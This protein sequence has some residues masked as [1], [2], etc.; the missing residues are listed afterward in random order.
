[1]LSQRLKQ[2][3]RNWENSH[4][5]RSRWQSVDCGIYKFFFSPT[6]KMQCSYV[7]VTFD[8]TSTW[9]ASDRLTNAITVQNNSYVFQMCSSCKQSRH[10]PRCNVSLGS[11]QNFNWNCRNS[12][13]WVQ[14][15]EGLVFICLCETRWQERKKKCNKQTLHDV[16][17]MLKYLFTCHSSTDILHS[18]VRYCKPSTNPSTVP[19]TVVNS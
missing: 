19:L 6:R 1:M 8:D 17:V 12:I 13:V 14:Y 9:K 10:T 2:T 5:A 15:L 18:L 3:C 7:A 16:D 11:L 4:N